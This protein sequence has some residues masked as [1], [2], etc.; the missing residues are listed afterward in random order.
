MTHTKRGL[1]WL[2]AYAADKQEANKY[3][4]VPSSNK[5]MDASFPG[6]PDPGGAWKGKSPVGRSSLESNFQDNVSL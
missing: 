4:A 6:P 3:Y 1:V 5:I 2:S